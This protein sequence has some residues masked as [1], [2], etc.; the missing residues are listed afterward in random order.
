MF[1]K[2]ILVAFMGT[3]ISSFTTIF[4]KFIG[5]SK[6][7]NII[8]ILL[9]FVLMGF[10]S[11]IY[12]LF[13]KNKLKENLD[14]SLI[15]FALLFSVALISTKLIFFNAFSISPNISYTHIII[16]LNIIFTILASYFL[17]EQKINYQCFIGILLC[18]IGIMIIAKFHK[19]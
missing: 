1:S 11:L 9:S 3:L 16:N 13:N 15:F 6:Y 17:F 2:W 5:N 4:I 10:I 7:D 18:I 8:F 14:C 12:L 19:M